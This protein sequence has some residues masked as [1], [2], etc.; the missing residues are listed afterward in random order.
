MQPPLNSAEGLAEKIS[1]RNVNL[2]DHL[3]VYSLHCVSSSDLG[4][5]CL[6]NT[7]TPRILSNYRLIRHACPRAIP[8]GG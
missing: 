5:E 8:D 7:F 1:L 4:V 3:F 2:H 6:T